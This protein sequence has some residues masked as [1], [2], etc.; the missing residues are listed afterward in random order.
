MSRAPELSP[1]A[2]PVPRYVTVLDPRAITYGGRVSLISD[3]LGEPLISWQREAADLIAAVD[4]D[5]PNSWR[6]PTVIVTVPRQSGK[7]T[8]LR[9]VHLDRMIRP[10]PDCSPVLKPA[11]I[12][13]TA[14]TG[15]DARKRFAQLA[16]GIATSTAFGTLIHRRDS[17]GSERL[18]FGRVSL[19]PFAPTP[20]ALHGET[21]AFVSIDEAWA[22][23]EAQ[24]ATLLAAITPTMQNEPGRQLIII[25]TAG[26][27]DSRWLY[28]LV[29][30]GRESVSDPNSRIAYLE[31]SA[32]PRFADDGDGDPLSLEALSF[33]P[34]IGTITTADD[35][36]T[37]YV[38]DPSLANIRRGFLNLWPS[39]MEAAASRDLVKLDAALAAGAEYVHGRIA[40]TGPT[41]HAFD[42]A[43]DR[44]GAAIYCATPLDA[45]RVLVELVES[46]AGVAWLDVGLAGLRPVWHDAT[47]YTGAAASRLPATSGLRVAS[48]IEQADATANVLALL[49]DGDL[50]IDAAP[51]L[52]EQFQTAAT[53]SA[54]GAG[55]AFDPAKSP[56][57]IDHLR[58]VALA[59]F[60]ASRSVELPG[61]SF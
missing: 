14:Q 52:R 4:P 22:F 34:A 28:Q 21:T 17:I 47:G 30:A 12:W 20:K 9:A 1:D 13:T 42:V 8:L 53:R 59:V 60:A 45:G 5:R 37:L 40:T 3:A 27:H 7:T 54:G 15:K 41:V 44:T 57:P 23:D 51:E 35:I 16:D 61:I 29:K 18:T 56:G 31:Y 19:S 25:S 50:I 6:Y 24:A 48:A 58:A 26:T 36:R 46:D 10:R 2:L 11:T 49:A 39:D 32:D 33:H 38:Q 55:F 43:S